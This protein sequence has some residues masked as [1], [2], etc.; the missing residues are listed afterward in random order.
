MKY[1]IIVKCEKVLTYLT[2]PF[3]PTIVSLDVIL[4]MAMLKFTRRIYDT[5]KPKNAKTAT[6]YLLLSQNIHETSSSS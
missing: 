4:T 6:M 5:K 3:V 2:L 1:N